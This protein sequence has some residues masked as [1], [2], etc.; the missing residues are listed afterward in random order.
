MTRGGRIDWVAAKQEAVDLLARVGLDEDP[1][2][3][4]KHLASASSSSS[5][6]PSAREE[7]QAAHPR[8]AHRGPQRG[9]LAAPARPHPRPEG[10]GI[11]SIIIS[12]KLNEIEQIADE[13]TIIRDGHSIETLDVAAG[14]GVDEDRIIRGGMVG[15]SLES[16]FPRPHAQDRRGLL[17]G[18]GLDDPAPADPPRATRREGLEPR[19]PP[20]RDRRPRGPHGRRPH[21]ARDEHLRPLVRQLRLGHDRQGRPGDRTQERRGGHR[22]RPRLRERRPQGA[23]AQPP[24]LDQALDRLGQALEDRQARRHRQLAGARHRR[25]LPQAAAHQDPPTSRPASPSSRAATSRRSSS[26]SGCSPTP[27]C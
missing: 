25:G 1:D 19:S 22:P 2:T 11:A 6:S 14:G 16:R 20:R 7:R 23:R 5:R 21:R 26:R 3:Q 4:I 12:H 24:R 9:R 10:K 15:R 27:T 8:R 18:E 17:P 13:I